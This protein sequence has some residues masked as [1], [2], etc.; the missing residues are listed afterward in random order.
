MEAQRSRARAAARAPRAADEAS[1]RAILEAEGPTVFVGRR[2]EEYTTSARILAVL[3]GGD[4]L[5]EVVLDRTPFYAESGGQVGDSGKIE[6]STGSAEVVDTIAALPGLHV[7]RARLSGDLLAGLDAIASIDAARR[8]SIRRNHTA[9]HLLHAALR[10]VLGEHVRQQGSL[11]APDRLRFDFS[12][13]GAPSPEELIEVATIVNEQLLLDA[14]VDT[15]ETSRVEAEAMG[16]VAFFGDKYG[17]VVR[18]VRA[19]ETSL[20]F[21]GG[22]HVDGLGSIGSFQI[23]SEGSIGSNTRRIEAVTGMDSFRRSLEQ[24][25]AVLTASSLLK[26]EPEQLQTAIERLMERVKVAERERDALRS[27]G[28]EAQAATLAAEVDGGI[29]VS[30]L[31]GI[32]ADDLRQLASNVQR[33]SEAVAVVLGS[34]ADDKVAVAVATDGT[35]DAKELVAQLGPIIGGGGGGSPALALAGG[36]QTGA[37]PDA[38]RA[39]DGVL[40]A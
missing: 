39:A 37:L 36:R 31:P 2:S 16:A 3:D 12:H 9:T 24:T 38:L 13:H 23:I 34:V 27:A 10:K 7:H 1:Y 20:E 15:L 22:T 14:E 33:R 28:L 17:E 40:R 11:V 32:G 8:E 4:G 5:S 30:S 19:G 6:S 21:C 29:L 35:C 26:S 18:V 25:D